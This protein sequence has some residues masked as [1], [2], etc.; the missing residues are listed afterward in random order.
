MSE[1]QTEILNLCYVLDPMCSWCWAFQ[2]SWKALQEQLPEQV[3]V[4]YVLGGLAPDS[5]VPMPEDMQQSI[6]EI[7]HSIERKTG[8]GFNYGFWQKNTPRRSTYPACRAAIAAGRL[9][10]GGL[11]EMIGAIQTAYYLNARNPSE[12]ETLCDIAEETGFERA[13]FAAEIAA[14][15]VEAAFQNNLLLTRKMGV[16]GFPTV[17]AVS[18]KLGDEKPRYCLLCAGYCDTATLLERWH[19]CVD[20]FQASPQNP[21][22]PE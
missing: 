20:G 7:W 13:A 2:P 14:P 3:S 15:E 11:V 22:F 4:R 9:R 6:Q 10:P 16:Q 18:T 17:I 19:C 8:A 5:N 12:V 1:P 21:G